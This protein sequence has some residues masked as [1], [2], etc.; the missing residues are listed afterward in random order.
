MTSPLNLVSDVNNDMASML[1]EDGPDEYGELQKARAARMGRQSRDHIHMCYF[2][3]LLL[4]ITI[5]TVQFGWSIGCWNSGWLYY[6]KAMNY[7]EDYDEIDAN[8]RRPR[9]FD[10]HAAV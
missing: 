4:T 7:Y 3:C 9:Y 1:Q 10:E 8:A 5:G 2:I 6:A